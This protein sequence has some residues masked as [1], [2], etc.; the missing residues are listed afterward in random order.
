MW[1]VSFHKYT[2]HPFACVCGV[3]HVWCVCVQCVLCVSGH[4]IFTF[5]A[6]MTPSVSMRAKVC[7]N[8]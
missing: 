5:V 4:E 2:G 8:S 1:I 7:C 6:V 3:V